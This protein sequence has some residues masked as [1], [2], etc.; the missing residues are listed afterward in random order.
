MVAQP[1]DEFLTEDFLAATEEALRR[2]GFVS[3]EHEFAPYR[4]TISEHWIA[5]AEALRRR[6]GAFDIQP[7]FVKHSQAGYAYFVFDQD[8]FVD[9]EAADE[10]VTQWLDEKYEATA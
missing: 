6:G 5:I 3:D 8:R 7:G 2:D 4:E 9:R 1:L 10:A